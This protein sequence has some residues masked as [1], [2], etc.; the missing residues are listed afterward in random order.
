MPININLNSEYTYCMSIN[1]K[2]FNYLCENFKSVGLIQPNLFRGVRWNRGSNTGC[3]LSHITILNMCRLLN[4]PYAII[5]EDD[6]YPR[7]DILDCWEIIKNLIPDDCG[8]LKLGNSSYRGEYVS[9]NKCMYKMKSGTAFGSH[10][11]IVRRELYSTLIDKMT[12]LNVPDVAMNYEYYSDLKFKPYVLNLDYHLFIQ[13]NISIDN[14]ISQ[15]GGQRYWYPN[16]DDM[17]GMTSGKPCKYFSDSLIDNESEYIED[18]CVI[19]NI[20]WKRG[21]KTGVVTDSIIYT[22]DEDGKLQKISPTS[23]RIKW[24]NGSDDEL[25]TFDKVLDGIYFYTISRL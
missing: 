2:R 12:E 8:I 17:K 21:K 1:K 5:Y 6:A 14:I 19:N 15:K 3:V 7:K 4:N 13:K 25:L 9:V 22:K 11:Y 24:S 20:N 18:M 23:W 10:A 16:P